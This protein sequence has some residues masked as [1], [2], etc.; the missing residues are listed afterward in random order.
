MFRLALDEGNLP[1]FVFPQ[2]VAFYLDDHISHKQV[3]TLYNPYDFPF[4]FK[5]KINQTNFFY[6]LILNRQKFAIFWYFLFH[7]TIY[8]MTEAVQA[9]AGTHWLAVLW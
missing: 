8:H 3:L 1:V 7:S 5:G 4:R 9:I 6:F 2:S